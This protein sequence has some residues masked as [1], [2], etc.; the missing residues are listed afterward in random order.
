MKK[1]GVVHVAST[2]AATDTRIFKKEC[3]SFVEAGYRVTLLLPHPAD[4]VREG[5]R[6]RAVPV[7]RTG[8]ERLGRT[9]RALYRA[10]LTEP[11]DAVIHFHDSELLPFMMMLRLQG[12]RVVYDA[13]EDT[14]LQVMHQH[15]IP[16]PLRR[17]MSGGMRV[18][19]WAGGKAFTGIV[20]AV[21]S[22]AS[23]FPAEKTVLVRNFPILN[24]LSGSDVVP[25]G[26]RP[27]RVVY[28]GAL[29]EAR[30]VREMVAAMG[31]LPQDYPAELV[32]GGTF[33]PASLAETVRT[34]PGGDRVQVAGWLDRKQVA[35]VLSETRVGLVLLHDT[36][37]Y[38]ESYPT[39]L[40]E[41]M[42]AG[43]PVVASDLPLWRRIVTSV[44]C[45]MVVDPKQPAAIAAAIRWLLDHPEEAGAM[46]VRGR[47]AVEERF[48][49]AIEARRLLQF[50]DTVI[51]PEKGASKVSGGGE[52]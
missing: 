52:L 51:L 40:F 20:A 43:I 7:P 44:G 38:R 13:H 29:T 34:L 5:V 26:A 2:H 24:E 30:G 28:V 10:A 41:Y 33:H 27:P 36:P 15:W 12:R 25:Y 31:C 6:I 32:L 35:A 4:E 42:S 18:L 22:I 14:P 50:Y 1:P 8:K 19:E 48:H 37:Q 3:R 47:R 39:K 21:P 23:R 46:G 11:V 45:G 17:P 49:W 16:G 9:L